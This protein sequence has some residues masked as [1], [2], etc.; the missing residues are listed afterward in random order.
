MN[1]LD[2]YARDVMLKSRQELRPE[3]LNLSEL[4]QEPISQ[5]L[6]ADRMVFIL[7][8][9]ARYV[10]KSALEQYEEFDVHEV[11]V[12]TPLATAKYKSRA[13]GLIRSS[14]RSGIALRN[15]GLEKCH[16]VSCDD[17]DR[18]SLQI[19]RPELAAKEPTHMR[20]SKA[21]SEKAFSWW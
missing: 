17:V 12:A 6:F 9:S 16:G 21:L 19:Y 8:R 13:R 14:K 15:E 7:P 3:L 4:L 20:E 10:R 11:V 1:I 5:L 18:H 2:V